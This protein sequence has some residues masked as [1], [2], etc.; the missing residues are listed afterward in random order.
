MLEN[1][2]QI[3]IPNCPGPT[4]GGIPSWVVGWGMA[5]VFVIIIAA[6]VAG[7][8]VYQIRKDLQTTQLH[9]RHKAEIE[10][11]K[12]KKSCTTCGDVYQPALSE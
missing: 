10:M 1:V 7:S 11:A 9:N 4:V 2:I 6:I 8:I 3:E 5:A 12:L